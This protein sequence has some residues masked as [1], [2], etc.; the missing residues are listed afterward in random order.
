MVNS[1]EMRIIFAI[2]KAKVWKKWNFFSKYFLEEELA[3]AE[4]MEFLDANNE[5]K[6]DQQ[7]LI[8][9]QRNSAINDDLKKIHGNTAELR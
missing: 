7:D 8:N 3:T 4:D 6:Q 5:L 1:V 9:S 2:L